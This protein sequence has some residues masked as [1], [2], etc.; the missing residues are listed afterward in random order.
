MFDMDISYMFDME[1]SICCTENGQSEGFLSDMNTVK[2][3]HNGH[4]QKEQKLV[5]ETNYHLMQVK[6][7]AECS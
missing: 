5:F 7:I 2:P 3:V 4:S 6:R 1:S